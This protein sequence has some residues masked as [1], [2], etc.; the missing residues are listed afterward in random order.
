MHWSDKKADKTYEVPD[1]IIDLSFSIRCKHLPLE[2]A[3]SF[4]QAVMRA[5]PWIENEPDC[6]IHLIHGAGSSNGWIR[7][8]NP[9][10]E[11]LHLSHRTR[12]AI[13][14]PKGRID[15]ANK[16]TGKILDIDGH[17]LTVGD[18]KIKS[19]SKL[20][21][22]FTRYLVTDPGLDEA[23]F[24]EKVIKSLEAMDIPVYKILCG[25]SHNLKTPNGPVHTRSVMLAE[26]TAQQSVLLQQRGL[27]PLRTMGCGL[28]I[29]HKGIAAVK[30]ASEK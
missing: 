12:M 19:L 20:D 3:Y 7:P 24:V 14:I 18:S 1:D 26:L 5:L 11:L 21:T 15:D 16:L 2:H 9:D 25:L 4:T 17:E 27:G 13:R 29:A 23:A 8:E 6:G 30:E 28:F 22:I 10:T